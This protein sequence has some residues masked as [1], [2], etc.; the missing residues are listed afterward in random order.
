MS[1]ELRELPGSVVYAIK[2]G[3]EQYRDEGEAEIPV[4]LEDAAGDRYGLLGDDEALERHLHVTR[5]VVVVEP[6]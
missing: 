1:P 4:G 2:K 6:A 3:L 5:I